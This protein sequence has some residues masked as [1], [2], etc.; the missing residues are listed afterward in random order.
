MFVSL[1]IGVV[2][3]EGAFSEDAAPSLSSIGVAQ[4]GK[5]EL[6]GGGVAVRPSFECGQRV[7]RNINNIK[8][9]KLPN[10]TTHFP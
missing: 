5:G 6:A 8:V 4:G 1:R 9:P 2:G 3:A 7:D 10:M